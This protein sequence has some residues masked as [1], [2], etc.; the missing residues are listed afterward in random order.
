VQRKHS[1]FALPFAGS[2]L[3]RQ[4]F[5]DIFFARNGSVF[6]ADEEERLISRLVSLYPALFFSGDPSL[7]FWFFQV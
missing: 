3:V 5:F 7:W 6:A 4:L 1:R 2:L